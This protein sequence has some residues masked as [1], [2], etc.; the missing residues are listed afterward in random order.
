MVCGPGEYLLQW[1]DDDIHHPLRVQTMLTALRC[2]GSGQDLASDLGGQQQQQ[3]AAV[4]KNP[5]AVVL[6][7]WLTIDLRR[8][9]AYEVSPWP[10]EGTI[11][12]AAAALRGCYPDNVTRLTLSREEGEIGEDTFCVRRLQAE[13]R[14]LLLHAPHLYG[15]VVHAVTH[16]ALPHTVH[17]F[18]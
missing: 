7:S 14:L 16:G 5:Q 15:Y 12:G 10:M 4:V 2:A 6:D 3:T 9:L 13:R 1:D 17:T 11:L 8:K 18:L